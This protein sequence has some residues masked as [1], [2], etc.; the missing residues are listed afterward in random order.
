MAVFTL[1]DSDGGVEVIVFP[2]TYQ[3]SAALL[4]TGTM[5]LA[6]GKWDETMSRCES[7]R[8]RSWGSTAREQIMRES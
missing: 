3:R 6:R 5:I 7:W 2:E 4:E 1:E 8:R